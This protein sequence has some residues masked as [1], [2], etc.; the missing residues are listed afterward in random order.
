MKDHSGKSG[1][2]FSGFLKTAALNWNFTL[3]EC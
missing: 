2:L 1:F 3:V